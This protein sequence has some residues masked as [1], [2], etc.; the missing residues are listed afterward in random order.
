MPETLVPDTSVLVDGRITDLIRDGTFPKARVLVP[1]AAL[2]ELEAQANRGQETGFAGLAE[3]GQLQEMAGRGEAKVEIIGPRPGPSELGAADVGAIDA[4]IREIAAE[5]G[6]TL[7]TSDRIQA[8]AAAAQ[9]LKHHYLRPNVQEQPD[10]TGLALWKFFDDETMSVH[11]KDDCV[12]MA[13]RGKPGEV[14]YVPIGRKEM[15]HKELRAIVHECIEHAKRDYASFL[16]MEKRGCTVLQV[17]PMRITI[18]QPPFSDG[19]ELTAVR[20]VTRLDLDHYDLEPELLERLEG[21]ARGVFIAGPP[22]S[23]KSTFAAAVA[24]HLHGLARVV[25]TMEQPR[26][27]QVRKEITQYG[28]LERDMRFTGEVT[29]LVRPD[30]II[31]DEVRTTEDFLTFADMRL[32]GV[33][34][35]GVTHANRAIDAVQRLI[36]RVELGMIPQVVDTILFIDAGEVAQVLELEFTVKMP[37][38]MMQ[39]DLARPVVVIRDVRTS[40]PIYE[41]YTF[42]EQV[43]V[44]P[45]GGTDGPRSRRSSAS[46]LAEKELRRS[47]QRYTRGPFEVRVSGET[48]TVMVPEQEVPMLIGKGG[49]NVQQL[50]RRLG[51]RLDIKPLTQERKREA[52]EERS[53]RTD[54]AERDPRGREREERHRGERD[55]MEA[56]RRQALSRRNSPGAAAVDEGEGSEVKFKRSGSNVYLFVLDG[57]GGLEYEVFAEDAR[58]GSTTSNAEG[59]LRFKADSPEGMGLLEAHKRNLRI[60]ARPV[61]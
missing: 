41:L 46:T 42:G 29:L 31:Y 9:G 1:A 50:E 58:I 28:A 47:L 52:W 3:L 51:I 44:M 60:W 57:P 19:L 40:R 12:P 49:R 4:M 33:G 10:L 26:D 59:R 17:G 48:A 14:R 36:G 39:E 13:K 20:P 34:L 55:E 56:E 25:K 15:A 22:G 6:A 8:H 61:A 54:R 35:I 11:L 7:V 23:G 43:V 37:E 2:A 53:G 30:H 38:G 24:E 27:L 32:A 21:K 18:A 5:Q 45:L 16:E